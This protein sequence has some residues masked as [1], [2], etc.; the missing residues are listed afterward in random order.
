MDVKKPA[1][2]HSYDTRIDPAFRVR[3]TIPVQKKTVITLHKSMTIIMK[4]RSNFMP[5]SPSDRSFHLFRMVLFN[6]LDSGERGSLRRAVI[7]FYGPDHSST[8]DTNNS[9]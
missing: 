3:S 5:L 6:F 1:S 2:R 4:T 9:K 8:P 7:R